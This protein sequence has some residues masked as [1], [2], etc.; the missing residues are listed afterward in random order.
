MCTDGE[1]RQNDF[2]K[3]LGWGVIGTV[4]LAACGTPSGGADAGT[5]VASDAAPSADATPAATSLEGTWPCAGATCAAGEICY[6]A[7]A[8]A[9][10]GSAVGGGQCVPAPTPCTDLRDCGRVTCQGGRC[11]G[12]CPYDYTSCVSRICGGPRMSAEVSGRNVFCGKN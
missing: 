10:G 8:G 4:L 9:D 6:L 11:S 5:D 7:V 1:L 12:L 2:M 3:I